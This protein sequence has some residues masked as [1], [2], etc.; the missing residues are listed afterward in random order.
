MFVSVHASMLTGEQYAFDYQNQLCQIDPTT[1]AARPVGPT[2]IPG[3]NFNGFANAL[4]GDNTFLY[5]IYERSLDDCRQNIPLHHAADLLV[6]VPLPVGGGRNHDHQGLIREN[7]YFVAAVPGRKE[8]LIR[9]A[10]D[11]VRRVPE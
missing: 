4:A 6:H 10:F 9:L 11:L 8:R 3:I 7:E 2:N 1:G 5:Y